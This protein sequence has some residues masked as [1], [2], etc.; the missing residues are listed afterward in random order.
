VLAR[1]VGVNASLNDV[2]HR[3]QLDPRRGCT[4]EQLERV[5]S[6]IGCDACTRFVSPSQLEHVDPP[7]ILHLAQSELDPTTG[8]FLTV[9]R[10][11]PAAKRYAT[12]DGTSGLYHW[13]EADSIYRSFSGYILVPV[14]RPA[15]PFVP[16]LKVGLYVA[17][18]TDVGLLGLLALRARRTHAN[19]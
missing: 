11:D 2:L 17:V 8:H 6:A 1:L 13:R 3:F 10:F 15:G 4:I 16:L 19:L 5:S 9:C 7:F 18:A 14:R 12:I